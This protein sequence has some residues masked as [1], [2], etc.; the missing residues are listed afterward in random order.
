MAGRVVEGDEQLRLGVEQ[1]DRIGGLAEH[2][3]DQARLVGQCLGTL[4]DQR[5]VAGNAQ[6]PGRLALGVAH[7]RGHHLEQRLAL[8]GRHGQPVFGRGRVATAGHLGVV[9]GQR[10]Q[11]ARRGLGGRGCRRHAGARL[12][13]SAV[14]RVGQ[15]QFTL[16]VLQPDRVGHGL[17]RV[18]QAALAVAQ[19]LGIAVLAHGQRRQAGGE[20]GMVQFLVTRHAGLAAVDGK[21]AQRAPAR[22]QHRRRPAGRQARLGCQGTEVV[23]DGVGG[24]VLGHHARA[25]VAGCAAGTP[26]GPDGHAVD[27]LVVEVGQAGRCAVLQARAAGVEQQHR[28]Q[29]ARKRRLVVQGQLA[30]QVGQRVTAHQ[31]VQ[32]AQAALV[33]LLGA[34]QAGDV[35]DH[36]HPARLAIAVEVVRLHQH[37]HRRAVAAPV[38]PLGRQQAVHLRD[39][40]ACQRLLLGH[41]Q[42]GHLQL[43]RLVG[44]AAVQRAEG[45]VD[46]HQPLGAARVHRHRRGV[47]REQLPVFGL[48]PAQRGDVA[49][50]AQHAQQ[51]AVR[52]VHRGLDGVHQLGVA[53]TG[54]TQQFLVGGGRVARH[55]AQVVGT[56]ERGQFGIDEVAV[57]LADD[58]PLRRGVELLE[59]RV[60]GQVHAVGVLQPDEI[61]QRIEDGAVARPVLSDGIVHQAHGQRTGQVVAAEHAHQGAGIVQHH[62]MAHLQGQQA[63]GGLVQG[64][65]GADAQHRLA[66]HLGQRQAACR[67]IDGQAAC[68]VACGEHAHRQ[69]GGIHHHHAGLGAQAHRVGGIL[70]RLVHRH[71]PGHRLHHRRHQVVAGQHAQVHQHAEVGLTD[72]AHQAL[73]RVHHA[74]VRHATLQAQLPGLV[75]GQA[76]VHRQQ[77]LGGVARRRVGGQ[78]AAQHGQQADLADHALRPAV[79]IDHRHARHPARSHQPGHVGQPGTDAHLRHRPRRDA[80]QPPVHRAAARGGHRHV[81]GAQLRRRTATASKSDS[82]ARRACTTTGSNWAPARPW[83]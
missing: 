19:A 6:H 75:A 25:G 44:G 34:V 18:G 80:V 15:Q 22:A 9:G 55:G 54:K 68:G 16:V 46:G 5:D 41:Q 30:Q 52:I 7:R 29:A 47:V 77:G 11:V 78:V 48:D 59:A 83:M 69:A 51:P 63:V 67:R 2:G 1:H 76:A 27:G 14:G 21:G 8:V 42:I 60:A 57:G 73:L 65:A 17:Q 58:L 13:Q 20:V 79:G 37:L 31:A 72:Q 74:Q 50:D 81:S 32:Q 45:V 56:E 49:A 35:G 28:T 70:Q 82:H 39:R 24:D 4:L 66:H 38:L 40:T 23:P 36:H 53:I 61:G 64:G 12:R 71:H 33:A 3:V 26:A 43:Q 10:R 62:Q